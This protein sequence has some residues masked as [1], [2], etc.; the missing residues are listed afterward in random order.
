VATSAAE[1]FSSPLTSPMI[2]DDATNTLKMNTA[3][4]N[5]RFIALLI[6]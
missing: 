2:F 5:S 3:R 4:D 6:Y 1:I